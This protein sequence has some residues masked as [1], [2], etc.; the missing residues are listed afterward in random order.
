MKNQKQ[1]GTW[2]K[3]SLK[4]KKTEQ[5]KRRMQG[6]KITSIIFTNNLKKKHA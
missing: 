6:D 1:Y 3:N 2:Y 5:E 4:K